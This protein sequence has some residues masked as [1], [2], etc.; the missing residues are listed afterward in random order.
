MILSAFLKLDVSD[1][2]ANIQKAVSGFDTL[3]STG[4][5]AA[6]SVAKPGAALAT[7]AVQANT[8]TTALQRTSVATKALGNSTDAS[9]QGLAA[10]QAASGLLSG[11][12]SGTAGGAMALSGALRALGVAAANPIT[13]AV[14]LAAALAILVKT[15][16][17][18]HNGAKNLREAIKFD[19]AGMGIENLRRGFER[20][21][22]TLTGTIGL[23][24]ELRG[25]STQ[26]TDIEFEK[27][28]AEMELARKRELSGAAPEDAAG[29]NAKYDK[30]R[31]E[32]ELNRESGSNSTA[33]AELRKQQEEN[34]AVIAAKR[35]QM[36]DLSDAAASATARASALAGDASGF[37]T[38]KKQLL[39]DAQRY[40]ESA[41][42]SISEAEKIRAEIEELERK[43]T[44]LAEQS[45]LY[46][47]RNDIVELKREA[48][49]IEMPTIKIEAQA[50]ADKAA[51]SATL[52]TIKGGSS[53]SVDSD[54]LSRIG[55]YTGGSSAGRL[56]SINER[57]LS[58][59]QKTR[60]ILERMSASR[61]VAVWGN[62]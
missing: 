7:T 31:T 4:S 41:K 26:G 36:L 42:N 61:N 45:S 44:V 10:A 16:I 20:F 11:T 60:S 58:E 27:S 6:P 14:A 23:M 13:L 17:D 56:E 15:M 48:A 38:N 3:G 21:M 43:N 49:G 12:L 62:A 9:V 57:Q 32:M 52:P 30:Q 59:A 1:F 18:A 5:S 55:G 50:V 54:R 51:D 35:T 22:G 24:R 53:L 37:G 34:A 29:I 2:S 46:E 47:R 19:N 28:V 40:G 8:A 25:L 33:A 39:A